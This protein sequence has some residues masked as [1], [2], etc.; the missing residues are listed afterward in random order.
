MS[1]Q[2]KRKVVKTITIDPDV[3]QRIKTAA[4]EQRRSL[5]GMIEI[6]LDE[7][8]ESR[9]G[10]IGTLAAEPAKNLTWR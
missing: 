5:S 6:A 1:E 7:W 2:Q 9:S 10:K 4:Q 8:L 3:Y